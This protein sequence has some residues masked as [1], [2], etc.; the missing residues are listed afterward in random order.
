MTVKL[1]EVATERFVDNITSTIDSFTG[2]VQFPPEI[3]ILGRSSPRTA[4]IVLA[5]TSR[6]D[7][8][9]IGVPHSAASSVTAYHATSRFWRWGTRMLFACLCAQLGQYSPSR[10]FEPDGPAR[11]LP[12]RSH[13]CQFDRV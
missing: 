5:R 8:R 1:T 7:S 10:G 2:L 12:V 6:T 13:V 9:L 4:G 3:T 11:G